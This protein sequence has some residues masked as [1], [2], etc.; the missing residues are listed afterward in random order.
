MTDVEYM[1]EKNAI[2][3]K[4][5]KIILVPENQ[6]KEIPDSDKTHQKFLTIL[7]DL[8]ACP[9]CLYYKYEQCSKCPMALAG[10]ICGPGNSTYSHILNYINP[11]H[12]K[13]IVNTVNPWYDELYDLIR[14]YNRELR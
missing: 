12:S 14:K 10:N 7:S 8:D 6:I 1:V 4:H 13:S 11:Y 9:Y 3:Y 5:T 2:L